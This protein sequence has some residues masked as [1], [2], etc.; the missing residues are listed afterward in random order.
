MPIDFPSG[1][2]AQTRLHVPPASSSSAVVTVAIMALVVAALYFGRE[3][4]VPIALS[5]LLSF[6]L[7][8]PVRWLRGVHVPR[9]LS[10]LLV[11]ALAFAAIFAFVAV[12][13]W[14]VS[15]LARSL[16]AYQ[17]NIEAKIDSFRQ[18]PPG[19]ALF[20]RAAEMARDI[21][22]KIEEQAEE[23]PEPAAPGAAEEEP[24]PI[25]VEVHEPNP[26]PMQL[27]QSFVG[28]LIAPLATAGIVIVFVIFMLLKR[29]DLRDRLIRLAGAHDLSRTTEALD[30]AA[31]RVGH[32]L[33][34]QLVVN[35]TYGLPVGIGLW[36]IGVPNPILWGML[37]TV[38]RF[39]P[40]IGPMISA[41]F[42]LALAIAVDPG[43]E[44]LLWTGALLVVIELIS[45]NAV[46]PWLY[47]TSTGLSPVAIIAAAIFWTW[48]WGPIGLL[49][50][51]PLTVCL[52]VLGQHV[53]QLAFLDVLFGSEPVLTPAQT[54]YHRLLVEAH[55]EATERAE[56]FLDEQSLLGYYDQ[57]GIPALAMAESDRHRGVLDDE[58]RARLV[59]SAMVLLDNL[60]EYERHETEPAEAKQTEA[61]PIPDPA[62]T[63]GPTL[64]A[65]HLVVCAGARGNLDE[66]AAAMLAQLIENQG[67]RTRVLPCECLQSRRL[68]ELHLEQV[69]VLV[70]S[71]MNADS[72]AHARFLV[73]RLRRRFPG[74]MIVIGFWMLTPEMMAGR[75]PVAATGADRV[76]TSLADAL[77][78]VAQRLGPPERDRA[79]DEL[80]PTAAAAE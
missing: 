75:D 2:A 46:E 76:V 39:V 61:A 13:A 53:P 5:A 18:A 62:A 6:A 21:G 16:P 35:V 69:G 26:T 60:G 59:E 48:L 28:P 67:G 55:D 20:D 51:T 33:L 32:Y 64:S 8:P 56:E 17:R 58:R 79:D 11:V 57:V 70:L 22:R 1:P 37:A 72:L 52:V 45:N 29:E 15:D 47:G 65:E 14:Q 44:T 43:W 50:S 77:E 12:V 27:L 3:V 31:R 30:D 63:A 78:E 54:L 25:P 10:V 73:R 4:F 19:G 7:A 41:F 38:L 49:L 40:Y 74:A 42:P 68:S 24:E 9:I 34:M 71:Y 36:L 80:V 23:Q 66:V